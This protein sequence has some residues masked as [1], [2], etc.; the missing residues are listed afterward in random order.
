MN[1]L[2]LAYLAQRLAL[3]GISTGFVGAGL[4]HIL[5]GSL[6]VLAFRLHDR[7]SRAQ[8]IEQARSRSHA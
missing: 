3:V 6:E 7:A 8:R 5:V 2:D 4:W 1:E